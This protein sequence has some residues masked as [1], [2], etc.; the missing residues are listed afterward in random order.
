[1]VGFHVTVRFNY[2]NN[3]NF[4]PEVIQAMKDTSK[5]KDISESVKVKHIISC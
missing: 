4:L 3:E 1:M 5:V 2:N